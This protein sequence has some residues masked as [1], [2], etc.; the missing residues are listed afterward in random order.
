MLR[1]SVVVEIVEEGATAAIG[2]E[3]VVGLMTTAVARLPG[4]ATTTIGTT[5][6]DRPPAIVAVPVRDPDRHLVTD[7]EAPGDVITTT[8]VVATTTIEAVKGEIASSVVVTAAEIEVV[9]AATGDTGH[10][11]M[12]CGTLGE[13]GECLSCTLNQDCLQH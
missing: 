13:L 9:T 12:L 4:I 7:H 5:G 6:D 10:E 2:I 3:V 1:S 11:L 8:I